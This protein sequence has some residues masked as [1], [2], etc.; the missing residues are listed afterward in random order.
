MLQFLDGN[1]FGM[2]PGTTLGICTGTLIHKRVVLSAGHC[3]APGVLGLPPGVR[4]AITFRRM[5]CSFPLPCFPGACLLNDVDGLPEP[6]IS[7]IGLIFLDRPVMGV[8]P[9]KLGPGDL[10][11]DVNGVRMTVVGYGAT[12]GPVSKATFSGVRRYGTST[13]DAVIDAQRVTF[14][15]DPVRICAGDSGGPTFYNGRLV[16]VVSDGH[17]DCTSAEVRARVD[18]VEVRET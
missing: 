15:R 12:R 11:G 16:A 13:L 1:P 3:V 7:D 18:S 9:A 10:D 17:E 6:V 2:A 14:N 8:K 5:T 4:L